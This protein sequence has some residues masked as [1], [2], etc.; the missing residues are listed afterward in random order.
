MYGEIGKGNIL[1]PIT[2]VAALPATNGNE[3]GVILAFAAIAI[4]VTAIIGQI[5]VRVV[6]RHY[7]LRTK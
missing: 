5:V 4:G 3:V 7:Q 2:G 6:R 1:L